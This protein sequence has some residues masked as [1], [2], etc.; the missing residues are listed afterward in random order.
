MA[1]LVRQSERIL[2]AVLSE[3]LRKV[4][5]QQEHIFKELLEVE[6]L[7][8]HIPLLRLQQQ[9]IAEEQQRLDHALQRL[10]VR[11]PT[12]QPLQ[13]QDQQQQD[14][15]QK[16]QLKPFPLKCLAD[17]G[18]HCYLPAVVEDGSR[19]LV[20]VGFNFFLEMD[21]ATAETFLKKKRHLLQ[22]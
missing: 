20:S 5:Q 22:Q 3:Q 9:H 1:A 8:D 13:Q 4:Q 18:S 2:D 11:P 21:L 19:L 15:Q 17:V 16:Q 7:R 6:N 10:R 12:P 14:K